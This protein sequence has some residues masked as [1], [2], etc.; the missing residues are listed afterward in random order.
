MSDWQ[1]V[2]HAGKSKAPPHWLEVRRGKFVTSYRVRYRARGVV[3]EKVLDGD[4]GDDWKQAEAAGEKLISE[5]RFGAKPKPKS[6]IMSETLCDEIVA[7]K[8]SLDGDTH[9]QTESMMRVHLKPFL[10]GE[11]AYQDD[12]GTRIPCPHQT[13]LESGSCIYAS[14]LNPTSYL[15]YKTHYRL[16]RPKG[17]LF[18]HWKFWSMLLKYAFDKQILAQ[19][20]KLEYDEEREDFR[21]RGQIIPDDHMKAFV[22]AANSNWRDRARLG[23]LTGQRPGLIR[24][25]RKSQV[26][27]ETGICKVDKSD[28]KNRR[29][30]SFIMPRQAIEI[31]KSRLEIDRVKDS[32][33]FFPMETDHSRPMDKHL[34]GWHEA[35]ARAGHDHGYTPHDL[36]H[37]YLTH[38]FKVSKNHALV[39]YS[40]DLSLDEAMATYIHFEADD[41]RELAEQTAKEAAGWHA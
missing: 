7:L 14:D 8:V 38:K 6:Q 19:R 37:T 41:T 12:S 31:L 40:C 1:K 11:C 22:G 34:N 13:Y 24:D 30:Y 39:C 32:P 18:N 20:F 35:W 9:Q 17:S 4:F 23:R 5:R 26:N 3:I 15:A 29:G 25:L 2:P 16:H 36:R 21:K 27:L 33:Y 28:S 10:R